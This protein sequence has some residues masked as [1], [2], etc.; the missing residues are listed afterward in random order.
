MVDEL[1]QKIEQLPPIPNVINELQEMY[2]MDMYNAQ[3]IEKVINKDPSLVADI[4]KVANSPYYGFA[5]EIHDIRQAAVLFGLDQIIEFALASIVDG[6]ITFDLSFYSIDAKTFMQ[7]SYLKSA[8]AK[9]MIERKKDKFLVGT[10]AFLS[11]VS[12][13]I[14]SNY[15][16]ERGLP[17]IN[18]P[19]VLNRLDEVEKELLSVDS[20]EVSIKIFENWNFSIEMIELLKSFKEKSEPNYRALYVA[21]QIVRIDAKVDQGELE[22]LPEHQKLQKFL[23]GA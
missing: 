11:D 7:L 2:Y 17:P 10:T 12:K 1:L 5:R 8:I 18:E 9:E 20:I 21:R 3:D 13:I 22:K 14:L 16:K 6:L 15:A 23:K 4:L 19:M